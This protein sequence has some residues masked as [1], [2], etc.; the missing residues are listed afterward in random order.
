MPCVV[1]VVSRLQI[2]C[3]VPFFSVKNWVFGHQLF[4]LHQCE[5]TH[6]PWSNHNVVKCSVSFL[7]HVSRQNSFVQNERMKLLKVY[8]EK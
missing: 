8:L 2:D 3:N 1:L 4:L 7:L 6:C 5:L